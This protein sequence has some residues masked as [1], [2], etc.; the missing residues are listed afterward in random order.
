MGRLNYDQAIAEISLILQTA[1]YDCETVNEV[2]QIS[3]IKGNKCVIVLCSDDIDALLRFDMTPYSINLDGSKVPCDKIIFSGNASFRPKNS[4]FWT[5]EKLLT[6]IAA[7][8]KARICVLP[9]DVDVAVSSSAAVIADVSSAYAEPKVQKSSASVSIDSMLPIR[10][11]AKAAAR[12]ARQEGSTILQMIPYWK[13]TYKSSGT[14][15]YK[16]KR[17][18]FDSEG[19]NWVNGVNGLEGKF[20]SDAVPISGE[21]DGNAEIVSPKMQKKEFEEM[22][23]A[24]LIKTLTRRISVN[25]SAGETIFTEDKE[26]KPSEDNIILKVEMVYV[27][28]WE[29][30]SKKDFYEVNAFTGELLDVPSGEGIEIY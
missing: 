18:S 19:T 30:C 29:I 27:P 25:V 5:L 8:A 12:I 16:G 14:V 10:Y 11:D 24:S 13:Y 7:A 26:F 22:I 15:S 17:A 28:V 9:F 2:F 4:V 6:I 1:G 3:A 21:V 23:M 20:A